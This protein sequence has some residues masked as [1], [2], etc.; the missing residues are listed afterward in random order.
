MANYDSK[1]NATHYSDQRINV[2]R[3]LEVVWGTKATMMFCEMNAFKYR[4]RVGKKDDVS[5]ELTKTEWYEKMAQYLRN[6]E[7]K[8]PGLG[9]GEIPLYPEF[10]KILNNDQDVS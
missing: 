5:Q 8:L 6:K 4:M 9:S 7:E 1:G 3:I 2:I 10:E